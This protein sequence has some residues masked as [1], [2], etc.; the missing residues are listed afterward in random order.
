MDERELLILGLL[1]A[2]SQHGYQ[3][4]DFIERNLGR[5]SDMKKSTAYTLLKRLN[6]SGY[7]EMSI[8]QE[9]NRPPKQVYSIT[10]LGAEKFLKL[11]K[12]TLSQVEDITPAGDI[13]I[14]FIDHLEPEDILVGLKKRLAKVETLLATYNKAPKHKLGMGIN[15][16]IQHRTVILTTELDWLKQTIAYFSDT[17]ATR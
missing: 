17:V 3:I 10:P 8:E 9:G 15:L 7:V 14:M 5:V 16:A 13:G 11:L 2:Q 12:A 1:T 6:Q 4:N